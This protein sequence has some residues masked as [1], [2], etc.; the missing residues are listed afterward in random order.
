MDGSS[1][2][3]DVQ[4]ALN[5]LPTIYPLAISVIHEYVSYRIIF[6]VEMG[7]VPH[8]MV[9][10]STSVNPLNATEIVTGIPSGSK[11]A[12]QLDGATTHYLDFWNENITNELLQNE[13]RELF[14][15]RCPPSLNNEQVTSSIV[16]VN[17]FETSNS[18]DE[19]SSLADSAFCGRN[20]ATYSSSTLS[21]ITGNQL[22]AKY[23]CFAYKIPTGTTI[24][25]N[26]VVLDDQ[27]LLPPTP[28]NISMDSLLITDG[29]WHYKCIDLVHMFG[30][31]DP[32]FL[33]FDYIIITEA[34]LQ[35]F[36]ADVMFDT[37]TLRTEEP[38]I[39]YEDEYIISSTDQASSNPC[40]FPFL[41]NGQYYNKCTLDENDLPICRSTSGQTFY[42]Q[43]SSIEGVRRLF[44][45]YQLLSNQF[46]VK[47]LVDNRTID[48]SFRY[49]DCNTPTLI[50]PL[51][52][53]VRNFSYQLSQIFMHDVF[54][55]S[56]SL[57]SALHQNLLMV[58][59]IS[60][61]TVEHI[62][63]FQQ[64]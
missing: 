53:N 23:M 62:H 8:L 12:F 26:F 38:P 13:F 50:K 25:M 51:P 40:V 41:Y 10:S 54:R 39:G 27:A 17:D 48:V 11:L 9:I 46:N 45:K 29:R 2:T 6:P 57:R 60:C 28:V 52:S 34:G 35:S 56:L 44:P 18:Y 59:M 55:M 15:I 21:L 43:S 1:E 16:Y 30:N 3:D 33:F 7:D 5:D 63:L 31:Y 42:C 4:S 20:R 24:V 47:H 49:T 36:L 19:A 32:F 37:V 64:R 61:S 22:P 58:L 14:T